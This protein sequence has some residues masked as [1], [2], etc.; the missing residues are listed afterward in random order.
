[1]VRSVTFE[2]NQCQ[3]YLKKFTNVTVVG[4]SLDG[5][6]ALIQNAVYASQSACPNGWTVENSIC[7]LN[8]DETTCNEYASFL[9]ITWDGTS[10]VAPKMNVTYKCASSSYT[11][12]NYPDGSY[13]YRVFPRW[14]GVVGNST[15]YDMSNTYCNTL[16]KGYLASIHS[17]AENNDINTLQN[18]LN[19]TDKGMMIGLVSTTSTVTSTD[20]FYW[21]DGTGVYYSNIEAAG[22]GSQFLFTLMTASTGKWST[23]ST[24]QNSFKYLVCKVSAKVT[25]TP[26]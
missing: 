16:T 24:D 1:M 25:M 22:T 6:D 4:R 7:T 3:Y 9:N 23:T 13:C 19:A 14:S 8:V 5:I 15:Y 17:E 26:M 18:A 12:R 11:A 2:S 10:C 20:N 21:L